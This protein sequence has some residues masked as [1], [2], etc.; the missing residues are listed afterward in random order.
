VIVFYFI[1]IRNELS[2]LE[3]FLS[4][5]APWCP[6]CNRFEPVWKE[7][8]QQSERLG[9][10]VGAADVNASPVLS[11]LFSVTSLPTVYQ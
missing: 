8:S 1:F 7:F 5:F 4:S 10:K 11:G 9:I 6:A 2:K 3:I